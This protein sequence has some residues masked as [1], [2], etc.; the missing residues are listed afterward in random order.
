MPKTVVYSPVK[1]ENATATYNWIDDTIYISNN[2]NDPDKYLEQVRKSEHSLVEYNEHYDIKRKAE[3][4]HNEA[5][6]I[7]ADKSVKGYEREKAR[8]QKVEAEI[9]LNEKRTAVR[10]NV[11]D[12]FV[13]EYGH[14]IHRHAAENPYETFAE[15]FLAMEKGETIP[16]QIAKII[17]D[18]KN[19]ACTK[20]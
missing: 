14:F 6:K 5:E 19:R 7:L 15:G 8:I 9:Q 18:A 11:T 13:H 3:Q 16:E 20:K 4:R 10:E 1:V 17:N 2:F 12:C